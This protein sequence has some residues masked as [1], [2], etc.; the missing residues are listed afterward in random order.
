MKNTDKI[1]RI[2]F[3]QPNVLDPRNLITF[4]REYKAH[5]PTLVDFLKSKVGQ[6]VS[7][8]FSRINDDGVV[9][10]KIIAGTVTKVDDKEF[11]FTSDMDVYINYDDEHR[12]VKT[13]DNVI[14]D[15]P[16][17]PDFQGEVFSFDESVYFE[18]TNTLSQMKELLTECVGH[19]HRVKLSFR[20]LSN[21]KEVECK[22]LKVNKSNI[23][24]LQESSI[25]KPAGAIILGPLRTNLKFVTPTYFLSEVA[26]FYGK[27]QPVYAFDEQ[28]TF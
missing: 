27:H 23:G 15:V 12:L 8:P 20:S 21:T 9:K 1:K 17:M 6:I 4:S 24:V 18:Y 28:E 3:E 7:L 22:I 25:V 11:T 14:G 5:I 26:V 19:Q 10:C 16:M 13:F 2:K